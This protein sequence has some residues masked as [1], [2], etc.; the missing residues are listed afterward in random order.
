LFGP[1][2]APVATHLEPFHAIP[3]H[4]VVKKLL[5]YGAEVHVI[6]STLDMI[7][8]EPEEPAPPAIHIDP[9]HA[10]A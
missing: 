1:D 7:V 4:C 6:P 3:L 2:G 10:T 5:V 9:F 8:V